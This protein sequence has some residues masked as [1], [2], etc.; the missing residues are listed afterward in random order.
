MSPDHR[1][2]SKLLSTSWPRQR[3]EYHR[4]IYVVFPCKKTLKIVGSRHQTNSTKYINKPSPYGSY[5][6][7]LNISSDRDST[8]FTDSLF[9]S[10]TTYSMKQF[11]L[12]FNLNIPW[13]SLRMFPHMYRQQSSIHGPQ[14]LMR[15]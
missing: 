13:H 5:P 6:R 7:L 15:L 2:Y 10:L 8:T 4:I 3:T 12:I 11:F 14:I 1:N 9:Q